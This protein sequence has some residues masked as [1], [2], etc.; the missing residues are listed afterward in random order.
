MFYATQML[1][2]LIQVTAKVS[3]VILFSRIFPAR[4]FQRT[5]WCFVAFLVIHGLIFLFV[6]VFQCIPVDGIWDK[7]LSAKCLDITA[8][9]WAGAIMSIIEDIAILV[10]P[11]P[12]LLKLQLSL[13]KKIAVF[14]MFSIGS[15]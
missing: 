1:Y 8:V 15:L 10:L 2:I 12:E 9:G 11:I 6:I 4:W 5:V 13:Q 14:I 3:I 7:S